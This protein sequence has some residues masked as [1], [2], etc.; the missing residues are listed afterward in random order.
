MWNFLATTLAPMNK[1][2]ANTNDNGRINLGMVSTQLLFLCDLFSF[3]WPLALPG[4]PRQSLPEFTRCLLQN[5]SRLFLIYSKAR[6][7]L[8]GRCCDCPRN[9]VNHI[10]LR[11]QLRQISTNLTNQL[12]IQLSK[13]VQQ[14]L[15]ALCLSRDSSSSRLTPLNSLS[16]QCWWS[17]KII[18]SIQSV[19]DGVLE[20]KHL[21]VLRD[22][23]PWF[24]SPQ[25]SRCSRYQLIFR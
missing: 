20:L 24:S 6:Q 11:L 22:S 10:G 7:F 3:I 13:Q 9:V 12:S 8:Y 16:C 15:K 1:S 2:N 14:V 21:L 18:Q 4:R 19:C 17:A 5:G 23:T 25:I